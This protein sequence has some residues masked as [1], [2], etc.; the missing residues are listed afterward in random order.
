M[1]L[2]IY[3]KVILNICI[4][5]PLLQ[6][7]YKVHGIH[8]GGAREVEREYH[9][10]QAVVIRTF[11]ALAVLPALRF[12]G[13]GDQRLRFAAVYAG[14]DERT[15]VL[16]VDFPSGGYYLFHH[17]PYMAFRESCGQHKISA[18]TLPVHD[19]VACGA[20]QGESPATVGGEKLARPGHEE[21]AVAEFLLLLY[22]FAFCHTVLL[23]SLISLQISSFLHSICLYRFFNTTFS[24][25]PAK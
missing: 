23:S 6:Q 16:P 25:C 9:S 13:D 5:N 3:N 1:F 18:F 14:K 19:T 21:T 12:F 7:V 8:R 20:C 11:A 15:V 17:F 24:K 22:Q 4:V 2:F 10:L